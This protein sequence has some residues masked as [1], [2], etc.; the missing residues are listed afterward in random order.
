MQLF[1]SALSYS[2]NENFVSTSKK[3]LKNV[4]TFAVVHYFAWKLEF[5]SNI[6]C[7]IVRRGVINIEINVIF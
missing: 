2:R 5:V 3:L 6:L 1:T 7:M 4:E